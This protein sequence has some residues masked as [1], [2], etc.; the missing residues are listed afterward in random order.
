MA[1]RFSTLIGMAVK[2]ARCEGVESK[3]DRYD[4]QRGKRGP[5]SRSVAGKRRVAAA[6][7]DLFSHSA[8]TGIFQLRSRQIDHRTTICE[9][10]DL[11]YTRP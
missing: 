1:H 10:G 8:K 5:G 6:N 7:R 2:V 11:E 9:V 3:L 4:L